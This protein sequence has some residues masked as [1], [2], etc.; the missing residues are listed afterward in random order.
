MHCWDY[1]YITEIYDFFK[2]VNQF[3]TIIL[4]THDTAAISS[5]VRSITCLNK[6]LYYH[7]ELELDDDIIQKTFGCPADSIAHGVPH[8]VLRNHGE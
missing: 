2:V 8:R 7:G 5:Y 1:Y 6:E 3:M 4:V